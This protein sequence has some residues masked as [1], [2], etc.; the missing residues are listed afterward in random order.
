MKKI[1]FISA[2]CVSTSLFA[3]NETSE[4]KSK[5]T[6]SGEIRPRMEYRTGTKSLPIGKFSSPSLF[7][8]QRTRLNA[9][10]E[11]DRMRFKISLQ[12]V[13]IWGNQVQIVANE[14]KAVSVHEAWGELVFS[15]AWS[16]RLGR[17]ELSYDNQ[18]ILGGLNWAQQAR[19]HDLA[20]VKFVGG[21]LT[22][23][24]GIAYNEDGK[25]GNNYYTTGSYKS[26]QFL[27]LGLKPMDGLAVS[28]LFLNNGVAKP[29]QGNKAQ[30]INFSQTVGPYISF[31]KDALMIEGNFYYQL[32][33]NSSGKDLNALN[34][35]FNA[36]YTVN[37]ITIGAGYEYLS[38]TAWD[39]KEDKTFKPFY[40]TNH[41]FN[42]FMD[43][44]YVGKPNPRGL[45]DISVK[46]GAKISNKF[47]GA[48]IY[49]NFMSAA[50]SYDGQ[51]TKDLGNEID[52]VLSYSFSPSVKI[53][54]GYSQFFGKTFDVENELGNWGF[55]MIAFQ[56]KFLK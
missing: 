43:L 26:M 10:Y 4:K 46:V 55:I 1:I 37:K 41:K 36:G 28:L 54:A 45:H 17:Q 32:G 24:L 22:A 48:V 53:N 6:L 8:S 29:V 19:S 9:G 11:G 33:K 51:K 50:E 2:V 27:H 56:P 16:L 30:D 49:H 31:R 35:L 40:G 20:L 13:R 25:A 38:G 14:E 44:F 18:R 5:F 23:D 21:K 39:E 34:F 52:I 47:N 42:G 12:D 15:P 3:Q 7:T